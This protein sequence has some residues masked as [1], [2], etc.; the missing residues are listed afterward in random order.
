MNRGQNLGNLIR[1]SFAA[2]QNPN[3]LKLKSSAQKKPFT[4]NAGAG[5]SITNTALSKKTGLANAHP[6]NPVT[7]PKDFTSTIIRKLQIDANQIQNPKLDAL[8]MG[9]LQKTLK[10][11]NLH[12]PTGTLRMVRSIV[13]I[14]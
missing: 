5:T 14:N 13:E 3:G 1:K 9:F 10:I 12:K 11:S 7:P 2:S 6:S 8:A 4:P